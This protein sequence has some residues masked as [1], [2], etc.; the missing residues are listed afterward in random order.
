[1][2]QLGCA[3]GSSFGLY[4]CS[5]LAKFDH[6]ILSSIWFIRCEFKGGACTAVTGTSELPV[7]F[8]EIGAL[9]RK[10]AVRARAGA[11]PG[12][13]WLSGFNSDMRGT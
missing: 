11:E 10:I 8:L 9:P 4:L 1:M 13:F 3:Q 12:L 7:T 6:E 5:T 2:S